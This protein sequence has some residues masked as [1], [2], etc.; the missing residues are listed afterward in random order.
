MVDQVLQGYAVLVTADRRAGDITAALSRRG[1]HVHHAPALS[2]VPHLDD[3]QLVESTQRL[4]A[5]PPDVV[6]VTTGIGFRGWLEAADAAGLSEPLHHLLAQ[7]RI[8]A[9]GPKAHGAVQQAALHTDWV[10]ES[11]TAAEL[12]DFLL[13]EGVSGL[14]VAVQHHGAGSDGIDDALT[15][16]GAEVTP[17]VV[18]RW[19]PPRDRHLLTESTRA[20]ANGEV[21]VVVFTSA[22]G[23]AAWLH[24]ADGAGVLP[25]IVE[26]CVRGHTIALAVGPVTAR[27]LVEAGLGPL[28]PERG[29]LGSMI[30]ALLAYVQEHDPTVRTR[31]GHVRLLATS[32]L[33]D[34]VPVALTPSSLAVL[35]VLVAS[36]G[37][38]VSREELLG[39]LPGSSADP[40][41]A[42]VAI[43]RLR[44]S[45]G[46]EL[47]QT[48]V[49]RGYRLAL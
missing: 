30:R 17:L 25:A 4:I 9:R 13:A 5:A 10:A 33:I 34:G 44:E 1:A 36:A 40:H 22:P 31:A 21:D 26:H 2:I 35:R 3:A 37:R 6:I 23:A 46:L 16:A 42:E 38:V 12:T 28:A 32:A 27:P 19:G 7:A 39:A 43:A 29:R 18:Y 24:A 47:I 11:E 15:H 20:V 14:R 45:V 8:V 48:V 41:A 49:K